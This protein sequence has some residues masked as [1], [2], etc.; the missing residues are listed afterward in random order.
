MHIW[1]TG[2]MRPQLLDGEKVT[3]AGQEF[4]I[5]AFNVK[6]MRDSAKA[7]GVMRA[8][9]NDTPEYIDAMTEVVAVALQRNC[10][11]LTFEQ[12]QDNLD[13]TDL[14]NVFKALNRLTNKQKEHLGESA[15]VQEM[16]GQSPIQ[17][18]T[19]TD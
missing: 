14:D 17:P 9:D 13:M 10:P 1:Y 12:V 11:G 16:N 2:E 5:P 15:A 3:V 4:T 18:T 8:A 7:R 19:G 6:Q